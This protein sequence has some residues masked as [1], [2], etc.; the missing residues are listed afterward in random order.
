ML[1][2]LSMKFKECIKNNWKSLIIK[3]SVLVFCLVLD[4]VSKT[5]FSN[6]FAERYSAGKYENINVIKG[7]L[8]F[9]Y[10]E[11]TGA[12]FSIFS[13]NTLALTIFSA[14]FIVLFVFID[15]SFKDKHPVSAVSCGLI[16]AGAIGNLVDRLFLK[17]V[18]DFISFDFLGNFPICNIAD[19][20]ITVGCAMYA[21]Y[22]VVI[23][24]K[25]SRKV[26]NEADK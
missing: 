2:T 6:V 25:S 12:A 11:N 3:L 13:N 10:T 1:Y 20:C 16:L 23:A 18:R 7:I 17:Y 21:I 22:F 4:L 26:K 5:I 24:I 8:S 9:T 19:V 15:Y 14:V